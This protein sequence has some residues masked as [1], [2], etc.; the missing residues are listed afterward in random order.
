MTHIIL[1]LLL[2]TLPASA[3]E[4]IGMPGAEK[5]TVRTIDS[6]SKCYEFATYVVME[7]EL[8][9]ESA[10]AD[11]WVK[12]KGRDVKGLCDPR[13]G[14][15]HYMIKNDFAEYFMAIWKDL[16]FLQST[17]G[18]GPAG[19]LIH[20]LGKKRKVFEGTYS[21]PIE[22]KDGTL[23]YWEG[24]EPATK[25]NCEEYEEITKGGLAAVIETRI[26]LDLSTFKLTKTKETRC[27]SR[28]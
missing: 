13:Q 6:T 19:L 21:D 5:G 10:G 28:Q 16:L 22:L 18:P 8:A 23:I 11:I 7:K 25:A 15:I 3:E 4:W 17:T 2:L 12:K 20:D 26:K 1:S 27:S 14:A 24:E 9:P